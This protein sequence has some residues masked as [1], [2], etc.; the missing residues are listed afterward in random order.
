MDNKHGP[1]CIPTAGLR[2]HGRSCRE[3]LITHPPDVGFIDMQGESVEQGFDPVDCHR[4]RIRLACGARTLV[5]IGKFVAKGLVCLGFDSD[6]YGSVAV[7]GDDEEIDVR[8][9]PEA[10]YRDA[11]FR[12]GAP[13][14]QGP[15]VAT[16]GKDLCDVRL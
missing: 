5:L 2:K 11:G 7:L 8:W 9:S 4:T 10:V 12:L 6:H 3:K 14:A 15:D 13:P 1:H 16:G